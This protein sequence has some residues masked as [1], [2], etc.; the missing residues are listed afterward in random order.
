MVKV[1]LARRGLLKSNERLLAPI[2]YLPRQLSLSFL[3]EPRRHAI[4]CD[5]NLAAPNDAGDSWQQISENKILKSG[6]FGNKQ[7]NYS[8]RILIPKPSVFGSETIYPGLVTLCRLISVVEIE[9]L[10]Y[11]IQ[12]AAAPSTLVL[13][14]PENISVLLLQRT[15]ASMLDV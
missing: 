8:F 5:G 2:I 10:P 1:T 11:Y 4:L 14:G 12:I 9:T 7:A 13:F 15:R 3:S 6:L